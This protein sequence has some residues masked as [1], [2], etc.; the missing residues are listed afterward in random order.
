M[1]AF[2]CDASTAVSRGNASNIELGIFL[3][4]K[5]NRN[6]WVNGEVAG[7]RLLS[8]DHYMFPFCV[9]YSF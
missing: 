7:G 2:D 8:W 9:R 5:I 4:L 1:E 6:P 3:N